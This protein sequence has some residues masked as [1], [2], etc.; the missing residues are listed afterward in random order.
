VAPYC[1]GVNARGVEMLRAIQVA[2][3]SRSRGL[4][5]GKLWV[6]SEIEN[7]RIVARPFVANDPNYNPNDSAMQR[8][9][10]RV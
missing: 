9:H 10:C 3:E 2:G 4:G 8:I 6:V 5:F 7:L 1:H